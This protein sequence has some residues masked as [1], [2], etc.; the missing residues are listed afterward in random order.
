MKLFTRLL[1]GITVSSACAL[2]IPRARVDTA[3]ASSPRAGA[4]QATESESGQA[5]SSSDSSTDVF[6]G[7]AT[8][9]F[10]NGMAGACGQ[11][12][13]DSAFIVAISLQRYGSSAG[14]SPLCG[15]SIKVTNTRN[16]NSVIVTIADACPTCPGIN[17]MDLSIGPF[18][19]LAGSL[20]DGLIPVSWEFV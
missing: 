4:S 13:P 3:L 10:Q 17:D 5:L 16:G 14:P 6:E 2:A 1:L 19:S 12:N 9:F 11:V 8:F 15:E 20:N 18:L 7:N